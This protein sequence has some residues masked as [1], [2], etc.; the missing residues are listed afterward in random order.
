MEKLT[1]WS[2]RL[3]PDA[4]SGAAPAAAAIADLHARFGFDRFYVTMDYYDTRESVTAFRMRHDRAM[5]D[6]RALLGRSV[7]LYPLAAIQLSP[8]LAEE[9][10]IE[11]LLLPDGHLPI[12]LPLSA[13]A[14]WIDT[15]L[16]RLLYK[17]HLSLLLLSFEL[18]TVLYPPDV[19][20]KLMRIP[21]AAFQF[22]YKSLCDPNVCRVIAALLRRGAPILL[23]T[24]LNAPEKC[25]AFDLD[26]YLAGA[27]QHLND[28]ELR[29][30]NAYSRA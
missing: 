10:E 5:E 2:C 29:R 28:A 26:E 1:D 17:R 9:R 3:V 16:N 25:A 12:A 8:T 6:M 30:L 11:R 21:G 19:I 23:G 22:G 13:Y 20:Q 24:S 27:A 7:R 18:C 14:D 15:A 4:L